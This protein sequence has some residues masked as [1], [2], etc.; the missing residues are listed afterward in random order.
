VYVESGWVMYANE[1]DPESLNYPHD[2]RSADA[3][4]DGLFQQ[5][6]PVVGDVAQRMDPYQ[7]AVL[8][9]TA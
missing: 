3:N 1:A 2:D 9:F 7:S 8:F 6:P 5:R 4:S